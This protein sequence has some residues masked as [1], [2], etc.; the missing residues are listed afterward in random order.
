MCL[1]LLYTIIY[2]YQIKIFSYI[3]KDNKFILCYDNLY[4][5]YET[6]NTNPL[7]DKYKEKDGFIHYL[8]IGEIIHINNIIIDYTFRITPIDLLSFLSINLYDKKHIEYTGRQYYN[9][10]IKYK[11]KYYN[12]QKSFDKSSLDKNIKYI[13]L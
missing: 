8:F 6:I 4:K 13:I 1:T 7:Y 12:L 10:Y 2:R 11:L 5:I 9:K 3:P